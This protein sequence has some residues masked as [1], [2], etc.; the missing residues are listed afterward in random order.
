MDLSL[1]VF[2]RPCLNPSWFYK[3]TLSKDEWKA[4]V[5]LIGKHV[6]SV[7][8]WVANA[9][10][11]SE[12]YSLRLNELTDFMPRMLLVK[13]EYDKVVELIGEIDTTLEQANHHVLLAGSFLNV[14]N[15][16]R[17]GYCDKA[18]AEFK[19]KALKVLTFLDTLSPAGDVSETAAINALSALANAWMKIDPGE[20]AF[21]QASVQAN[22]LSSAAGASGMKDNLMKMAQAH[23]AEPYDMAVRAELQQK[24]ELTNGVNL[25]S[26][27][28]VIEDS[29]VP[30]LRVIEQ[31]PKGRTAEDMYTSLDLVSELC[32]GVGLPILARTCEY[33]KKSLSVQ[34]AIQN[35]NG[36]GDSMEARLQAKEKAEKIEKENKK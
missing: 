12:G 26:H 16:M 23:I 31:P 3:Q 28:R 33:R 8:C 11:T 14:S 20:S 2:W 17:P 5:S 34:Q 32:K 22:R 36:L 9:F 10:S 4:C 6:Q 18:T 19:Q 27:K 29:I 30:Y 7:S 1:A 25:E 24:I 21:A 13:E 35:W 15:S